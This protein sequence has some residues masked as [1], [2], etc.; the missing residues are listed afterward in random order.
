MKY[1]VIRVASVVG[2]DPGQ[3]LLVLKKYKCASPTDAFGLW[4]F[5]FSHSL[6]LVKLA[7][8]SFLALADFSKLI[9]CRE[10]F[11][12][13]NRTVGHVATSHESISTAVSRSL[14][15]FAQRLYAKIAL[16]G[17]LDHDRF[18]LSN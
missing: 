2:V 13:E 17:D 15:L 9:T 6:W 4:R 1:C 12:M 10:I 5:Q 18:P 16:P 11:F 3:L 7:G 14:F 8:T